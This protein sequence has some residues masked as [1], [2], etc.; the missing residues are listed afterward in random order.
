MQKVTYY[1]RDNLPIIKHRGYATSLDDEQ[2]K[3]TQFG[4]HYLLTEIQLCNLY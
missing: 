4:F 2:S 3:Q 1:L